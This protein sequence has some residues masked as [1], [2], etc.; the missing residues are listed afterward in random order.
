MKN[1]FNDS[2]INVDYLEEVNENQ[3]YDKKNQSD[4]IYSR[5]YLSVTRN[6][7]LTIFMVLLLLISLFSLIFGFV[8]FNKY[9]DNNEMYTLFVVHSN[10]KYGGELINVDKYNSFDNSFNYDFSVSNN[11]EVKLNYKIQ[12]ENINFGSDNVDYSVINYSL[13]NYNTVVSN[14]KIIN[15]N[16]FDL[17]SLN[18]QPNENHQMVLKLWTDDKNQDLIYSFKIN[19]LV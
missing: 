1:K 19:I 15:D 10:D 13:L 8:Y 11:N 18:I 3:L 5:S 2:G 14:G 16:V 6:V 12:V 9:V 4:I 7:I 17:V